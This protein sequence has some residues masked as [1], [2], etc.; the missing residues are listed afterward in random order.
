MKRFF[1]IVI[2]CLICLCGCEK[3]EP[4]IENP[5]LLRGKA[6]RLWLLNYSEGKNPQYLWFDQNG[7]CEVLDFGIANE[8]GLFIPNENCPQRVDSGFES[9]VFLNGLPYRM[10]QSD[11]EGWVMPDEIKGVSYQLLTRT[12]TPDED[13]VEWYR[14]WTAHYNPTTE[15]MYWFLSETFIPDDN[16]PLNGRWESLSDSLILLN[17][18]SYRMI[19]TEVKSDYWDVSSQ[20]W[21]T[22]HNTETGDSIRLL[23][24]CFPSYTKGY[25]ENDGHS[26]TRY[27]EWIKKEKKNIKSSVLLKG[28]RFKLYQLVR[29]DDG[30]YHRYWDKHYTYYDDNGICIGF[31]FASDWTFSDTQDDLAFLT[32]WYQKGNTIVYGWDSQIKYTISEVSSSGDTIRLLDNENVEI[33]YIDTKLPPSRKKR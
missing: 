27:E 20:R 28:E 23:D 15:E 22:L 11:Y 4:I 31:Y 9:L 19:E 29:P 26:R 2:T 12:F 13:N 30:H 25:W 33:L 10:F 6:G 1:N 7:R 3:Q 21:L 8:P 32:L 17:G 16:H 24:A 18:Q 14:K 5:V